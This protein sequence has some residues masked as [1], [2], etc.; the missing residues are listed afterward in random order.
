[1]SKKQP[2]IVSEQSLGLL[3]PLGCCWAIIPEVKMISV[4]LTI[5]KAKRKAKCR[6]CRN[7]IHIN[8]P[9]VHF[10]VDDDYTN[11][12]PVCFHPHCLATKIIKGT[13]EIY[14][15]ELKELRG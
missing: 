6:L 3:C 14:I 7:M 15:D 13:K 8:N 2:T 4:N 5:R 1:M 9:M 10:V 12:P 11:I